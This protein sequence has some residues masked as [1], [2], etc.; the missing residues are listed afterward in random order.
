MT[1]KKKKRIKKVLRKTGPK[2]TGADKNLTAKQEH[3]VQLYL[4]SGSKSKAYKNAFDTQ[5]NANCLAVLAWNEFDKPHLKRRIAEL[6]ERAVYEHLV[7]K[8]ILARE[9]DEA[10]EL[11]MS[12]DSPGAAVSASTAK[13]KLYGLITDKVQQ[14]ISGAGGKSLNL[15]KIV[16][17]ILH[18]DKKKG[19][20]DKD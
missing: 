1:G 14:E 13:G 8:D 16:I 20:R 18:V 3:A 11:A 12:T 17:E 5:G 7:T 4:L 19:K 2:K 10:R 15:E 9:F 6:Q